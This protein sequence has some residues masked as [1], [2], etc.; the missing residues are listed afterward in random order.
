MKYKF[1]FQSDNVI[2]IKKKIQNH[3]GLRSKSI[4]MAVSTLLV[5]SVAGITLRAINIIGKRINVCLI[6]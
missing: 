1:V 2:T 4:R 5:W 6:F 3:H